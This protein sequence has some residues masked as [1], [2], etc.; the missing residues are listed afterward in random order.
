MGEREREEEREERMRGEAKSTKKPFLGRAAA[1]FFL[2]KKIFPP[3]PLSAFKNI[4]EKPDTSPHPPWCAVASLHVSPRICK[5]AA[6]VDAV[7]RSTQGCNIGVG[8]RKEKKNPCSAVTDDA[9]AR[10][11]VVIGGQTRSSQR[12]VRLR[13][14]CCFCG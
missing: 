2:K 11:A 3:H 10:C 9:R 8:E 4:I 14:N 1:D 13:F 6:A 12:R 7:P 5:A